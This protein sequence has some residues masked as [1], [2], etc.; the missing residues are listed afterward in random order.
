MSRP[1]PVPVPIPFS[2]RRKPLELRD[3]LVEALL[4][5]VDQVHLV[6]G[7][8]QVRNAKQRA[9]ESMALGLLQHALARV[10]QDHREVGRRGAGHHVARVLLVPGAV[11]DDEA[12]LGR[13]EVAVGHIDRDPLLAL[14]AEPV[15]QQRQVE[16]ALAAAPLA[17]SAPHGRAGPRT[18]AWCHTR[19]CRSSVLLPSSTEPAVVK[20]NRSS[21]IAGPSQRRSG[22]IPL[23]RAARPVTRASV[24]QKK[25]R[26]RSTRPSCDPPSR[27]LTRGRPRASRR[28][29]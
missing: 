27:P 6:D 24:A 21:V 5:V 11:G 10:E 18:P 25:V 2:F 3:E 26:T 19:A 12:A 13:G 15:G 17:C 1:M 20:R 7:H 22:E 8:D 4:G 28:A 16:R 23:Q 9:D 14:G 29:R